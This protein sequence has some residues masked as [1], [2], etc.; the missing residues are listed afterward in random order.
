MTVFGLVCFAI[1]VGFAALAVFVAPWF[2]V[3]KDVDWEKVGKD[4]SDSYASL[5]N[6]VDR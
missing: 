4:F 6:E 2:D 1:M 5:R 3:R